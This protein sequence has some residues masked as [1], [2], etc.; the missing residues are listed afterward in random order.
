MLVGGGGENIPTSK[1]V[2]VLVGGEVRTF[3]T[4]REVLM[5]VGVA[6]R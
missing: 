6:G 1:E 2:L 5:L 3:P 4:S